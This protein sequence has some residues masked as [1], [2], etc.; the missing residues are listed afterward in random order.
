MAAAAAADDL[1]RGVDRR[2]SGSAGARLHWHSL[3]GAGLAWANILV[4]RALFALL[5]D[6]SI[7]VQIQALLQRKLSALRLPGF[8]EEVRVE[9]VQ[10][11]DRPPLVHRI[12]APRLDERGTWLDADVT[13]EGLMHMTISTKL[14]LL[15]LR[16]QQQQQEQQ[17]D[18]EKNGQPTSTTA[19]VSTAAATSGDVA[20]SAG[21]SPQHGSRLSPDG[22]HDDG[23]APTQS[24][25][26]E[27]EA[28]ARRQLEAIC[29][30]DAESSGASSSEEDGGSPQHQS[31]YGGAHAMDGHLMG[32]TGGA[33]RAAKV[34]RGSGDSERASG[35]TE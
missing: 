31:A 14:N 12:S 2:L 26:T 13:Y 19:T 1:W 16:R 27:A 4:G 24:G 34:D 5:H 10:L 30:S 18:A 6:R 15:R 35:A 29:D 11:G 22:H 25:R 8:M 32:A 20:L 33:E 7:H 9:H 3:S 17:L 28:A 23:A 21:G